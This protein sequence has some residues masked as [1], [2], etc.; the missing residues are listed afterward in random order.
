MANAF[1]LVMVL[2]QISAVVAYA[3][4]RRWNECIYWIGALTINCAVYWRAT[5]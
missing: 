2:L 5:H 3:I 1:V 4:Q